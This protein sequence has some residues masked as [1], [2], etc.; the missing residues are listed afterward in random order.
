M[1][2]IYIQIPLFLFIW[3]G[4]TCARLQPDGSEATQLTSP[5]EEPFY[6]SYADIYAFRF[7]GNSSAGVISG[8]TITVKVPTGTNLANLVAQFSA[9]YTVKVGG[10][11]QTSG[12]TANN[13][14]NP[15]TYS[16]YSYNGV[17]KDYIVSVTTTSSDVFPPLV[18]SVTVSPALA[19]TFPA[20][21]TMR[22]YFTDYGTGYSSGYIQLCS[23]SY[24]SS[25]RGQI[26]MASSPTN[27]G[28]YIEGTVQIKNYNEGGLWRVCSVSL[29][30]VAGNTSYYY[31]STAYSG[32]PPNYSFSSGG[33]YGDS[34]IAVSNGVTVTGTTPDTT[35]PAV[36]SVT[37]TPSSLTP[38]AS[39]TVRVN[40][41]ETGSGFSS[42]YAV[43]CSPNYLNGSSGPNVAYS[44]T[45]MGGYGQA[46]ISFQNYNASG[47]WKVCGASLTDAIGNNNYYY[48]APGISTTN[49]TLNSA[50]SGIPFSS[51]FTVNSSS[52]DTTTPVLTSIT[53]TPSSVSTYPATVTVRVY[54]TE[55]GAGINYATAS[56]C[57]PTYLANSSSGGVTVA[58]SSLANMGTYMQGTVTLQSYH[59]TG[60]WKICNVYLSDNAYNS[61]SYGYYSAYSSSNYYYFLQNPNYTTVDSG[62]PLTGNVVKN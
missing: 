28:A 17:R 16:V 43:I 10:A 19:G 41:A 3:N 23:P 9:V 49:F 61:R 40:Y 13:F 38:P 35:A 7:T 26:L 32:N 27:A 59:E 34:G 11:T 5:G 14:T 22:A 30:D 31:F 55:T 2:T 42:G 53:M 24:I 37:V 4:I 51:A 46:T 6:Y 21:I 36:T 58:V 1:R 8:N 57:S 54:Y 44:L 62:I 50:D 52:P 33:F 60:N 29:T 20:T 25:Y 39:V 18:S 56:L 15:V 45:D 47:G 12:V 48:Y